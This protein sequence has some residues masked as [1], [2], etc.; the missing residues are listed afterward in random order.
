MKYGLV[1]M[2]KKDNMNSLIRDVLALILIGLSIT[3]FIIILCEYIENPNL[4]IK[5][6][7]LGLSL[8]II[9][10]IIFRGIEVLMEKRD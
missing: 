7:I 8:S 9:P 6:I 10:Y 3:G 1:D 2:N 5:T 4:N